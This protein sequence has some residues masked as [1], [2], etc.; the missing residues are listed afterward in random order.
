V[1]ADQAGDVLS[2]GSLQI[3][4]AQL[5]GQALLDGSLTFK[6]L[7]EVTKYTGGGVRGA[8]ATAA[9][10]DESGEDWFIAAV[11]GPAH[12]SLLLSKGDFSEIR[13]ITLSGVADPLPVRVEAAKLGDAPASIV[14]QVGTRLFYIPEPLKASSAVS[15][16][17]GIEVNDFALLPRPWDG[18]SRVALAGTG[19]TPGVML[20]DDSLKPVPASGVDLKANVVTIAVGDVNG[21]RLPDLVVGTDIGINVFLMQSTPLTK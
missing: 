2:T 11:S 20:M 17:P 1:A 21:D 3:W 8:S 4:M 7:D 5:S 19:H 12:A 6:Q 13:T 18:T 10:L 16:L 14:V 15:P 9:A